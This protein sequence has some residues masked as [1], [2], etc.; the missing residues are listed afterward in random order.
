MSGGEQRISTTLDCNEQAIRDLLGDSNDV[1]HRDFVCGYGGGLEGLMVY[2]SGLSD[3]DKIER[4]TGQL[5]QL[6]NPPFS[7]PPTGMGPLLDLLETVL[8]SSEFSLSGDLKQVIDSILSGETA[9]FLAGE[10][11][12]ILLDT[13]SGEG[14]SISEPKAESEVRGPKDGFVENMGQNIALVRRRLRDPRMRVETVQVG[15]RTSTNV[16]L[17]Y[18]KGLA[19]DSLVAEVYKRLDR[20]E[21]DGVLGSGYLEEMIKDSPLSLFSLLLSTER[22]DRV[23][24]N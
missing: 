8:A 6:T 24:A 14:R 11:R 5:L 21:L 9:V 7:Q 19:A 16:A 22:P 1:I 18:M 12:A 23:T 2:V 10:N 3:S 4:M 15:L 20:I 17:I 13:R